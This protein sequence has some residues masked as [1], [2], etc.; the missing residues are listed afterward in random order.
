MD[1]YGWKDVYKSNF[2]R[3]LY[4]AAILA[5]VFL[6]DGNWGYDFYYTIFGPYNDEIKESLR[7]LSTKGLITKSEIKIYANRTEVKYNISSKGI[8]S[9]E[10]I[11]F[12]IDD[13]KL[14]VKWFDIVIKV[15]SIYGN[16]FMSRLVKQEPNVIEQ[17]QSNDKRRLAS[18]NSENNLSKMLYEFL[19]ERGKEKFSIEQYSDEESVLLFFEVLYRKYVE[20]RG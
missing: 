17:D 19:K 2:Q 5:P 18:D 4:F 20:S 10:K 1:K 13:L 9:C 15:L 8:E 7:K 12:I 16:D 3:V 6:M 11:L 14:R